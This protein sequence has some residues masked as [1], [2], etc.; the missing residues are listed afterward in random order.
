MKFI[1]KLIIG[2]GILLLP[3]NTYAQFT[4]KLNYRTETGIGFSGGEHTPFW[5]TANKQGLSSIEKNNGYLRA[6]IFR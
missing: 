3:W 1:S 6:G 2:G 4:R 5:L